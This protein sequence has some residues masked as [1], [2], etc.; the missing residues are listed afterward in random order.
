[1]NK[2]NLWDVAYCW[3][4]CALAARYKEDSGD[5]DGNR[6]DYIDDLVEKWLPGAVITKMPITDKLDFTYAIEHEGKLLL[7]F[8][9]TEGNLFQ[10]GWISN[11]SAG[12]ETDQFKKLGGHV[13][14]IR[15]GEVA[16]R[17]FIDLVNDYYDDFRVVAH[18]RGGARGLAAVR[19]WYRHTG[20]MPQ[21]VVPFCSPPVFNHA[22][23]DEY[24]KSGLGAIT[25]RPVMYH[26]AVDALGL[27][28]LK[29]VGTELK[30]PHID[31]AAI[32]Q[33]GIIGKLGYGHAYSS[34]F[35]CLVRY[36]DERHFQPEVKW[37]KD[38]E[39]VSKV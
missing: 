22:A 36:C 25:I 34:I 38:T 30:L 14:F 19:W 35:E 16:A 4:Y 31:T 8:L 13:D 21:H 1:M 26:D 18:S 11:F 17:F 15:S 6:Y 24:D 23:A 29:H 2:L 3:P 28:F 12:L 27:P 9:G 39:W 5:G 37:L 33:H 7:V 10:P 20:A 32:R